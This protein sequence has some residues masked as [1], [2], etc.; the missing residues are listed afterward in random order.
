MGN[1]SGRAASSVLEDVHLSWDDG[2]E[3]HP[4]SRQHICPYD[5]LQR[6]AQSSCQ[7]QC[8]WVTLVLS[9]S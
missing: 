8:S 1:A 5:I 4:F 6:C 2:G 7:E 9:L 3:T